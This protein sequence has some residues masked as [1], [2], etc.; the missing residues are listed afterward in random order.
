M[1]TGNVYY[2][3]N[4]EAHK[5]DMVTCVAATTDGGYCRKNTGNQP[6]VH[7]CNSDVFKDQ[8]DAIKSLG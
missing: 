7:L 5:V 4:K 2:V 1:L 8:L 6:A 3:A